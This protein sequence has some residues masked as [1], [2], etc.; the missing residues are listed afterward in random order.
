MENKRNE[1]E[2]TYVITNANDVAYSPAWPGSTV[3]FSTDGKA[4]WER[5]TETEYSKSKGTLSWTHVHKP[6]DQGAYFSYFEP[7]TYDR[8]ISLVDN[9]RGIPE[10]EVSVIGKSLENRDIELITVGNGPLKCWVSHRQHPGETQAEVRQTKSR[11]F[12]E[13]V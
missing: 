9:C 6:N 13:S 10:V 8:H 2:I 12:R 4:S 1:V 5:K 3:C 11:E 7:F